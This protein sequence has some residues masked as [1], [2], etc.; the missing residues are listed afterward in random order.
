MSQQ[1]QHTTFNIELKNNNLPE[2]FNESNKMTINYITSEIIKQLKL[3][4]R[5]FISKLLLIELEKAKSEDWSSF[6]LYRLTLQY[7]LLGDEE[8]RIK[9]IELIFITLLVG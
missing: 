5:S 7:T 8:G 1:R 2:K 9:Y 3:I 6:L 4:C